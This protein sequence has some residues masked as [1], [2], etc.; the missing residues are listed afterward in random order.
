MDSNKTTPKK[1]EPITT[2]KTDKNPRLSRV[3]SKLNE[4]EDKVIDIG[5]KIDKLVSFLKGEDELDTSNKGFI[6]KVHEMED[7]IKKLED[8][9][10]RVKWTFIGMGVP[11]GVGIFEIIKKLLPLFE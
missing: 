5:S 6:S 1:K 4:V 11:A 7:R 8:L 10:V 3:E 2:D 9:L